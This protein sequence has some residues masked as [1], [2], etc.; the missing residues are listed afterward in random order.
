MA[1]TPSPLC[2]ILA[3]PESGRKDAFIA[4][5]ASQWAARD[6]SQPERHR[7]YA[8]ET[9]PEELLNLLQNGSLFA[10]RK[11]VEY[12]NAENVTTK[13]DLGSLGSYL[14][15][16]APDAVLIL[17]TEAYSLPKALETAVGPAGKKIFWELRESEKPAWIRERLARDRISADEDAIEA[18]LEMVEN[19]TS[20][21]DSA[22][23]MLGA[24][25][26]E[27]TRLGADEVEACLSRSRREDAFSL[28]DR[29]AEGDFQTTLAVLDTL[30]SD[31]QTDPAQII[32]AITWSFRKL[33]RLRLLADGGYS[34]D[35][36]MK[37]EKI[38]SKTA[39]KK[40]RMAMQ[41]YS[42]EDCLRIVRCAS[43]TEAL[44][45]GGAP[46]TFTRPLL[47]LLVRAIMIKKGQGL[48]LSGWKERGY[49]LS[50]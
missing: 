25:F 10:S 43:E 32:A 36:A 24:C 33:E 49:Y 42:A 39:Q 20:A 13:S 12:R 37:E 27:D 45:R 11:L 31:R 44:L 3:G 7:L 1:A 23:L 29:M 48:V 8:G 19:E 9:A 6:G 2:W 50:D 16:P 15:S 47:H 46:A 35:D 26:P 18:I 21:L 34:P 14:A 4:E 30:L 22:C 28:F 17:V 5:L 38:T 40:F 41:R